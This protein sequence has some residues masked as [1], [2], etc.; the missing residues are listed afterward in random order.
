M[1][2]HL[3]ANDS[4]NLP[5]GQVTRSSQPQTWWAIK[6]DRIVS[7]LRRNDLRGLHAAFMIDCS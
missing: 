3:H 1:T 6:A 2:V 7:D 5:T 4:V